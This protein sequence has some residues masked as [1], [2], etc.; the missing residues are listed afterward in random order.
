MTATSTTY[1]PTDCR[2][3][4]EIELIRS[5][6]HPNIA[7]VFSH[8]TLDVGVQVLEMQYCD[9]GDLHGVALSGNTNG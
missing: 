7:R 4:Q 9:G 6:N 8:F 3:R 2:Y 5:V 1:Y